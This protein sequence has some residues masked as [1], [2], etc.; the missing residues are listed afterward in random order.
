MKSTE[1]STQKA[2]LDY[3]ALKGIFHWRNNTGAFRAESGSFI[4]YGAKGS[5]DIFAVKRPS[6]RLVGIEVKDAKGRLTEDQAAFGVALARA[7]GTYIVARS[8]DDVI[9]VF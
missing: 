7:G 5:P 8:L 9:T 4:R 6:G 1:K 2:I 3:L